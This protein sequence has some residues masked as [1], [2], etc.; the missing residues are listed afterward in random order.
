MFT[1]EFTEAEL[2]LLGRL[3]PEHPYKLVDPLLRK[4]NEQ[5]QAQLALR[6]PLPEARNG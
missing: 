1:I 2:L 3:L 4:I 6:E 5:V